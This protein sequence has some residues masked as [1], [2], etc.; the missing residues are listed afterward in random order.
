MLIA[1]NVRQLCNKR[2]K[3]LVTKFLAIRMVN[4]TVLLAPMGVNVNLLSMAKL[5]C[6]KL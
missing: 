5:E 3:K 2:G 1:T 6:Q 4:M